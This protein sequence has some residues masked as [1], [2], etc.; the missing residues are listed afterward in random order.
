MFAVLGGGLVMAKPGIPEGHEKW[1][2]AL[3][4]SAEVFPTLIRGYIHP[5]VGVVFYRG[6][7]FS[8]D[9]A[10]EGEIPELLRKMLLM[11]HSLE[12]RYLVGA[13]AQKG[14]V[15]EIWPP[16]KVLGKVEEVVT[17]RQGRVNFCRASTDGEC[18]WDL[19]PQLLVYQPHC[20]LDKGCPRCLVEEDHC[21]C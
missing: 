2:R 5:K 20:P 16:L 6:H 12:F 1:L 10:L 13:G 19:C 17:W 14:E 18:S 11:N 9:L 3:G 21:E 8:T 15:G 7:D 4:V